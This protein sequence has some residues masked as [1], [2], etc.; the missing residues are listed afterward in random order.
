[1]CLL[2]PWIALIFLC[3]EAYREDCLDTCTE[4]LNWIAIIVKQ[5]NSFQHWNPPQWLL[6]DA[7]HITSCLH[8]SFKVNATAGTRTELETASSCATS[9]CHEGWC[10]LPPLCPGS[11]CVNSDVTA[12]LGIKWMEFTADELWAEL[13]ATKNNLN[14]QS[15]PLSPPRVSASCHSGAEYCSSVCHSI[16]C[17]Y[18]NIN[19]QY[20]KYQYYT[21]T[22]CFIMVLNWFP[23]CKCLT[24]GSPVDVTIWMVSKLGSVLQKS[25][26]APAL[27]QL[28]AWTKVQVRNWDHW[29]RQW[30]NRGTHWYLSVQN[31]HE[32]MHTCTS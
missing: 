19:K 11:L 26:S 15:D 12:W 4:S 17:K 5:I 27:T 13:W 2:N 8:Y 18:P 32:K 3:F 30:D 31:E 29:L 10:G 23:P 1:M 25:L 7:Q 24:A 28:P 6:H 21:L 22:H 14:Q 9:Q 20:T 16:Y